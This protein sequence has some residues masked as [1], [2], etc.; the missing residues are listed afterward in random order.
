MTERRGPRPAEARLRRLLVM[1]PWLMER[2]EVPVAEVAARFALTEA[3]PANAA[4]PI[5]DGWSRSLGAPST[6]PTSPAAGTSADGSEPAS[7]PASGPDD[8][9]SAGS[10]TADSA[11]GGGGSFLSPLVIVVIVAALAIG[12]G[13]MLLRRGRTGT[14]EAEPR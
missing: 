11:S 10:S 4:N 9:P 8:Q 7:G 12:G 13:V 2:A 1:L 3:P 6:P 14:P 5:F